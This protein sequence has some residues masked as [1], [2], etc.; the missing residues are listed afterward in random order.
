MYRKIRRQHLRYRRPRF[1]NR[2]IEKGWLAPSI[3]NQLNSH[4]RIV[5]KITPFLSMELK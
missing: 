5:Q 3:Q 2:R 1:K 4:V